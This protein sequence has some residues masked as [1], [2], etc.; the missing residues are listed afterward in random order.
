VNGEG[1]PVVIIIED[2][3]GVGLGWDQWICESGQ[4]EE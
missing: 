4:M 3:P 2:A 1:V